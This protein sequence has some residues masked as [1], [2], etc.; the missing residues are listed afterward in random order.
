MK[1]YLQA[2]PEG[3]IPVLEVKRFFEDFGAAELLGKQGRAVYDPNPGWW[4]GGVDF[5]PMASIESRGQAGFDLV[6]WEVERKGQ[7]TPTYQ[8]VTLRFDAGGQFQG[9]EGRINKAHFQ[10]PPDNLKSLVGW[11][12]QWRR[13]ERGTPSSLTITS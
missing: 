8:E 3:A 9:G 12:D 11:L 4:Q 10:I 6:F 13:P 1:S 7:D 5:H 2:G